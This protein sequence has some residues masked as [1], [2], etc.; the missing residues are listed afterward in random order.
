MSGKIKKDT[1]DEEFEKHM[2]DG[3]RARVLK[4]V[5]AIGLDHLSDI[6]V[7]EYILFFIF[8]R[9]DVNP[10][11]HR[12][13]QRFGNI[14]SILDAS[15]EDLTKVKGMGDSSAKKLSSLI[16]IFE[17]YTL[18]KLNNSL[19]IVNTGTYYDYAET[20]LR[21]ED[22]EICYIFG[23]SPDGTICHSRVFN[24]GSIE[25]VSIDVR[26][27]NTY[28]NTFKVKGLIFA[29]NHPKG[30][31][32]PSRQDRETFKKLNT[33]LGYSGVML[34][35]SIVVGKNGIYSCR[36]DCKIREFNQSITE[37]NID[38]QGNPEEMPED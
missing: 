12:L 38:W 27:I 21:F 23:V 30:D 14:H 37:L 6:Q 8:P 19:S 5:N 34:Y 18:D 33:Y 31:C 13:L 17:V 32:S 2:H 29:H 22:E 28:I 10:L 4:T 20:L 36:Q 3:H 9:G 15:I 11:A 1:M 7:V 24:R 35:D 16:R 26:D 25:Q